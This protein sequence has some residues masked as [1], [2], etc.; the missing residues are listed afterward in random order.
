MGTRSTTRFISMNEDG[1]AETLLCFYRQYDG[2]PE[3]H[4]LDV[5]K[6]INSYTVV[7]GLSVGET[8]KVANGL[9]C[10]VGQLFCTLKGG[11]P[12]YI[13]IIADDERTFDNDYHYD[14]L[15]DETRVGFGVSMTVDVK[16]W[17]WGNKEKPIFVGTL[18]E[19]IAFANG[20]EAEDE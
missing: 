17:K 14:F 7:N 4:G 3:G 16:V 9:G 6:E 5:A 13:Y 8:R 2:Y 10:L 20:E 1:S 18:D 12:G 11:K 15:F 19:F